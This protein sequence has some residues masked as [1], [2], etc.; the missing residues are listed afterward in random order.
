MKRPLVLMLRAQHGFGERLVFEAVGPS[1][2]VARY[3][4][5]PDRD[6][7][8]VA[9]LLELAERRPKR[10]F[11]KLYLLIRRRGVN[12]NYKRV[13]RVY[14]EL[15]LNRR[16]R[17]K[18]RI[19]TR[20]PQPLAGGERV[21]ACWSAKFMSDALWD[22]RRFRT[23]NDVDDYN[24][25]ALAIEI[26]LNLSAG[27]VIRTLDRIGAW[28]GYPERLPLD[29]GSEV[30]AIALADWAEATG[31]QV[32]FIEPG[33]PMQN[34][35][36][37]RFNGSYRTGVLDMYVFR[38]LTEARKQTEHWLQDHT[39]EIPHNALDDLTPIEYRSSTTQTPPVTPGPDQGRSTDV[40]LVS[41][42]WHFQRQHAPRVMTE[43]QAIENQDV[44]ALSNRLEPDGQ[45]PLLWWLGGYSVTLAHSLRL[46]MASP[47]S[48]LRSI[49]RS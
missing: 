26:D 7:A 11:D 13:Y 18:K 15:R 40:L 5:R 49:R 46:A 23:F 20:H 42:A 21:T 29:N 14:C 22:G 30:V 19:P 25:E 2:S 9:V 31:V 3:E 1:R 35:F 12:W 6:D 37:E 41:S 27:R 4:R 47:L 28:R 24:R 32:E 34:G 45:Q 48:P 17:V 8:M 39:E 33:R 38:N 16:R 36:I 43:A 44:V 10:G